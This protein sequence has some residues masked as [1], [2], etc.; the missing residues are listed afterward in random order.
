MDLSG[1]VLNSQGCREH[2][3]IG[4]FTLK[5]WTNILEPLRCEATFDVGNTRG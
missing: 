2:G 4:T 1:D 3:R 5:E